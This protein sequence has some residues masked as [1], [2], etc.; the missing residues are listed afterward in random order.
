MRSLG[1]P[2][3]AQSVS[4]M[5]PSSALSSDT[6]DYLQFIASLEPSLSLT[7]VAA[8][9]ALASATSA[10][11]PQEPAKQAGKNIPGRQTKRGFGPHAHTARSQIVLGGGAAT[12]AAKAALQIDA[13]FRKE[14]DDDGRNAARASA[15]RGAAEAAGYGRADGVGSGNACA[16]AVM[17]CPVV[18][19]VRGLGGLARL[20]A[21]LCMPDGGPPVT[22]PQAAPPRTLAR[23]RAGSLVISSSASGLPTVFVSR[24][25]C[26]PSGSK[27]RKR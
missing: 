14:A 16:V 7:P 19:A 6:V 9:K 18:A 5:Q 4:G 8:A 22:L 26:C 1:V 12:A 21:L 13:M 25:S 2:M 24:R 23:R 10:V 27:R 11:G 3:S 15:A 20:C 17:P